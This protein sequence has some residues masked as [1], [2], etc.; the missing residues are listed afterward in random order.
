VGQHEPSK[1]IGG[2]RYA[3]DVWEDT[4]HPP[5]P[6]RWRVQEVSLDKDMNPNGPWKD[7]A[8]GAEMTQEKALQAAGKSIGVK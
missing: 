4:N 8:S 3:V 6:W 5:A 1:V 7:V 2:V